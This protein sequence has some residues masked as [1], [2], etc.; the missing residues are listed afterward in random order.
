M[1]AGQL[2]GVPALFS[3]KGCVN[4]PFASIFDIFLDL[5]GL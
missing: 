5:P 3:A 1:G 4:T 2:Q